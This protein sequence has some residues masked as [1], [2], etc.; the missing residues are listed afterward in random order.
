MSNP[1]RQCEECATI[2]EWAGI[3]RPPSR[4]DNCKGYKA[5]RR[6]APAAD[7]EKVTP[8]PKRRAQKAA[9][10]PRKK[11]TVRRA[12]ASRA[13]N[14]RNGNGTGSTK[15]ILAELRAELIQVQEREAHLQDAIEAM[16]RLA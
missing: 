4:C 5:E 15:R 6:T 13:S 2:F 14:N 12:P 1:T 10:T 8:A 9:K 11:R 16:E 7:E 3:G